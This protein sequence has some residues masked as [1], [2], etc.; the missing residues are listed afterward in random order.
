MATT[1]TPRVDHISYFEPEKISHKTSL[2][3]QDGN[4]DKSEKPRWN[5]KPLE[6]IKDFAISFTL[7]QAATSKTKRLSQF[8][9]FFCISCTL[10][11]FS[12]SS[13]PV[14]LI[15]PEKFALLFSLA[16]VSLH[17]SLSCLKENFE[18]YLKSI[19]SNQDYSTVSVVYIFSLL[20]TI[21]SSIYLGSYI[22]VL[23]SCGLQM[24][25]VAWLM[26]SMFPRSSQGVLTILK[27]GL[28]VCPSGKSILPI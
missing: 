24:A 17:I 4:G 12:L 19:S 8:L 18:E 7:V 15:F 3:T 27:L 20:F 10:F 22:V 11:L 1:I 13:L 28:K 23:A 2:V 21:Y 25:S 5:L 9:I 16:S 26:Y 6:K 14:V